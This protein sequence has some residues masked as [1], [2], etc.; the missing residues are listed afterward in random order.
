MKIF[1][2][3]L[4][5]SMSPFVSK[6]DIRQLNNRMDDL[7]MNLESLR[8]A[9]EAEVSVVSAAV[10]LING[11]QAQLNALKEA[12]E[13]SGKADQE[14]INNMVVQLEAQKQAL[15]TAVE[16]NTPAGPKPE[17]EPIGGPV[18]TVPVE[19][20]PVSE[21]VVADPAPGV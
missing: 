17:V 13:A 16:T 21:D 5:V 4:S 14:A 19:P 3:Y 1:G 20:T 6:E 8:R 11:F 7:N 9:V 2:F 15:A 18:V 10:A 12:Q